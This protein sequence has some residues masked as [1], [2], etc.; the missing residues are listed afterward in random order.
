MGR[1]AYF[2]GVGEGGVYFFSP[3]NA[4]A[5]IAAR[6]AT[7]CV[8]V[9]L[10]S[11]L[12]AC[13]KDI[14][15][16]PESSPPVDTGTGRDPDEDPRDRPPPAKMDMGKP[17]AP[18]AA[19]LADGSMEE[20]GEL[21]DGE[22]PETGEPPDMGLPIDSPT[23]PPAA[24]CGRA[25][26]NVSG[27]TNADGMAIAADGTIFYTQEAA[28]NGWVGRLTP[29]G[30]PES[31]WLAIPGGSNL[32][33]LAIDDARN[34]LYISSADGHAIHWVSI[35]AAMPKLENLFA[36]ATLRA[37]ELT[38]TK[39]GDVYY[40]ETGDG[41]VYRVTPDGK[42]SR[43]TASPIKTA[44]YNPAG[45]AF[46]PD[47]A[48]YVGTSALGPIFRLVLEGGVEKERTNWGQYIGWANGL[49]F[50]GNG[51]LYVSTFAPNGT[52]AR[53]VRIT[54]AQGGAIQ[55]LS[56]NRFG[57]MAFGRGA[58]SCSDLYVAAQGSGMQVF[59]ADVPGL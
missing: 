50:D 20:V 5:R 19:P 11:G 13:R 15:A 4:A 14:P 10:L 51:R 2:F 9:S 47:G 25:R 8:V 27:I 39:E 38:V 24:R 36:N 16:P 43:V 17:P 59:F 49:T 22:A 6:I 28:P 55:L 37:N 42:Q 26:S 56:G 52:E 54:N 40:T 53:V 33:A 1:M 44:T 18:D 32:W 57:S 41:H 34:R 12:S 30:E 48:L 3:S 7:G 31:Q 58:L 29:N 46:G 21:P 45:L 35:K 23:M